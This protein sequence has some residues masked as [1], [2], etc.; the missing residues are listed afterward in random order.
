MI[1]RNNY[2]LY[3][4]DF[5][6]GK[7]N[8]VQVEELHVFLNQ[9]PDLNAE[10]ELFSNIALEAEPV[11]FADKNS[12][13]KED[14]S[15]TERLI[16]YFEN[17]LSGAEKIKLEQ[18]LKVDSALAQELDIVKKTRVLP[19][20]TILFANKSA[21]KREAKVISFS[22]SLYRNLSIAASI[23]LIAI[24]YFIFRP[25]RKDEKMIA[26]D[27]NKS[28]VPVKAPH[29]DHST[30]PAPIADIKPFTDKE[31]NDNSQKNDEKKTGGNKLENNKVK[32]SPSVSPSLAEQKNNRKEEAPVKSPIQQNVQQNNLP[33]EKLANNTK[34]VNPI[35][36]PSE[37]LQASNPVNPSNPINPGHKLGQVN[38]LSEVFT[39]E[40]LAELGITK[41]D[42]KKSEPG[43][44]LDFAA[45]KLKHFSDSKDIA[46]AKDANTFAVNV[47]KKFS[48]SHT[49]GK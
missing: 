20:Y 22:A 3:I 38:D 4:I 2:E 6:D 26:D 17:D 8:K 23:I 15:S 47:G 31:E 49:S 1:T 34:I 12:L 28:E 39:S 41:K 42:T 9:N 27:K 24:A 29:N 7:L 10:F 48:V 40:E 36:N 46:V 5:Y 44:I 13:K 16:A 11:I 33:E 18:Q 30:A 43:N 37:S 45:E 25:D 14:T 19:D 21:L 35:S 32:Q